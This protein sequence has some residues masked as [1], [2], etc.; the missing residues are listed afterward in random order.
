MSGLEAS[1]DYKYMD[2]PQDHR[3]LN[4][5]FASF[6]EVFRHP[7]YV[8]LA[9][10]IALSL[11]LATI[12]LANIG[13][14][15][16]TVGTEIF[17]TSAKVK[18]LWSSLRIFQTG[19]TPFS[20]IIAIIIALLSGINIALLAFYFRKRVALQS[21]AGTSLLGIVIGF[22]GVGCTACGSVILSSLFGLTATAGFIGLFPLKGAEIGLFSIL[23]LAISIGIVAQKIQVPLACRIEK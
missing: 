5:L 6:V 23:I 11:L 12:W 1:K 18:I 22:L 10:A 21:A 7:L 8:A 17:T 16:F 3:Y 15:R 14:V 20:Q 19:F 9:G 4:R 2:F 13:F